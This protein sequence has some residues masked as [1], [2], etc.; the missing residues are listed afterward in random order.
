[1]KLEKD[2]NTKYL[3][4]G[5][6]ISGL[7]AAY[8]LL[9]SGQSDI[10]IV[11]SYTVGS[12]STGHSAGMLVCE[13]EAA[14]WSKIAHVYG[15]KAASE[16]YK[17]QIK[18][19]NTISSIIKKGSISCDYSPHYLVMVGNTERA[20][21]HILEDYVTRKKIGA[22]AKILNSDKKSIIN[23]HFTTGERVPHNISVNPLLFAR[24]FAKYLKKR[25]VKIY[26]HTPVDEVAG[27]KAK[28][29]DGSICFDTIIECKGTHESG[30]HID[31]FLTTIAITRK[32]TTKELS[33]ISLE[34]R[35]M[36]IDDLFTM[37]K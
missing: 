16:Y 21:K 27:R 30:V 18:A 33:K 37:E 34:N 20:K 10:T 2:T 15:N 3:I 13:P 5:G 32:L 8:F 6:G 19:T 9:E 1:M 22:V 23:K 25:G 26:E 12:G 36:F 14:S 31:N 4:I 11:E 29:P 7:S 28:T 17:A 35:D 24:G